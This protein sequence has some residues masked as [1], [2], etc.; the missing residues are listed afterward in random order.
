M[1]R[2]SVTALSQR[3]KALDLSDQLTRPIR[4]LRFL[5][6]RFS[7]RTQEASFRTDLEPQLLRLFIL[8]GTVGLVAVLG[9]TVHFYFQTVTLLGSHLELHWEPKSFYFLGHVFCFGFY[10]IMIIMTFARLRFGWFHTWNWE[11]VIILVICSVFVFLVIFTPWLVPRFFGMRRDEVWPLDTANSEMGTVLAL[12]VV[13]SVVSIMLPFR[14]HVQLVLGLSMCSSYLTVVFVAGSSVPDM[15]PYNCVCICSLAGLACV[16]SWFA[17]R[18][19][20]ETWLIAR[21][22][23]EALIHVREQDSSVLV[24]ER[25]EEQLDAELKQSQLEIRQQEA[26]LEYLRRDTKAQQLQL[27][28]QEDHILLSGE[29]MSR[30]ERELHKQEDQIVATQMRIARQEH[31]LREREDQI[32]TGRARITDQERNLAEQRNIVSTQQHHNRMLQRNLQV[33]ENFFQSIESEVSDLQGPLPT[34]EGPKQS[35]VKHTVCSFDGDWM[36]VNADVTVIPALHSFHIEHGLVTLADGRVSPLRS[37]PAGHRFAGGGL[38]IKDG[39][40]HRSGKSRRTTVYKRVLIKDALIRPSDIANVDSDISSC[41]STDA[42]S[43]MSDLDDIILNHPE[44]AE[45]ACLAVPVKQKEMGPCTIGYSERRLDPTL[46]G[47]AVTYSEMCR[48]YAMGPT[49]M[50]LT[51]AQLATHWESLHLAEAALPQIAPDGT[52]QEPW[53][54]PAGAP[55]PVQYEQAEMLPSKAAAM[56]GKG[57]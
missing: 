35:T 12:D 13:F 49:E 28:E 39:M 25:R 43:T 45:A 17:E 38:S 14:S 53:T 16:G 33:L 50:Q 26:N 57:L 44:P 21:R 23:D 20:R 46:D 34:F 41:C 2:P 31:E 56:H 18:D 54:V 10:M 32:V 29:R 51:E 27:Q 15:L 22:L 36:L 24:M 7:Q 9:L 37:S 4:S 55:C 40:L 30:Q 3:F 6:L 5:D 1:C 52:T 47:R 19:R 11:L 48:V 42:V 8:S